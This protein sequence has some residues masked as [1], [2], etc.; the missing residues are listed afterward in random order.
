MIRRLKT[1]ASQKADRQLCTGICRPSGSCYSA[2]QLLASSFSFYQRMYICTLSNSQVSEAPHVAQFPFVHDVSR[3]ITSE[4]SKSKKKTLVAN[5]TAFCLTIL[6]LCSEGTW[7]DNSLA[8]H[9][10]GCS[11]RDYR[12]E[13]PPSW[14][15]LAIRSTRRAKKNVF[16]RTSGHQKRHLTVLGFAVWTTE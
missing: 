13:P 10:E 1:R 15:F 8:R 14:R 12:S 7:T 16:T 11:L 9:C 3:A 6:D 4:P 2:Q 5:S